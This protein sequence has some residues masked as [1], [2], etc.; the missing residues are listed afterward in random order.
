MQG[1]NVLPLGSEDGLDFWAVSDI[2]ADELAEF[3]QKLPSAM[4]P[5]PALVRDWP[6]APLAG[7]AN[8]QDRDLPLRPGAG[9]GGNPFGAPD[10]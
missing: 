7:K 4:Q 10:V 2:N 6:P 1:F 5:P 3:G 8:R 9:A